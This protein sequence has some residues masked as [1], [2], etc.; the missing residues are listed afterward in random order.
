M[1]AQ[2]AA[3]E[4]A[5]ARRR[6]KHLEPWRITPV[7]AVHVAQRTKAAAPLSDH[8]KARYKLLA[9]NVL[10][11]QM[12]ATPPGPALLPAESRGSR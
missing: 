7:P 5:V 2:P 9:L 10:A 12:A 1:I 8:A 6:M 4:M 3:D 11:L